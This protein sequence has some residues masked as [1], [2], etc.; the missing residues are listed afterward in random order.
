MASTPL[1]SSIFDWNQLTAQLTPIGHRR[2]VM[3]AATATLARLAT[4]ISTV[5]RGET[6]HAP[7]AHAEEEIVIIKE[8]TL[9]VTINGIVTEAG[10]GSVVFFASHDLHGM[11]NPGKIDASYYVIRIFPRDLPSTRSE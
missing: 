1:G 6:S 4:H 9:E 2:E 5:R 11:R 10:P 7:H 3:D 8:G